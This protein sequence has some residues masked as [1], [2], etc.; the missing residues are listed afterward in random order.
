MQY[1]ESKSSLIIVV[2][3]DIWWVETIAVILPNKVA[4][5]DKGSHHFR[6][7]AHTILGST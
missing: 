4:G 2:H 6:I 5:W 1:L 3:L 7:K